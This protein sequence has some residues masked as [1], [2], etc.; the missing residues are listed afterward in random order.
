M[1]RIHLLFTIL[2]LLTASL[3]V[4]ACG[5]DDDENE[6][7]NENG[8]E[9][10]N[11]ETPAHPMTQA[12]QKEYLETVAKELMTLMPSTDFRDLADLG[13]Y[14]KDIYVEKYDWDDVGDWASDLFETARKSLGTTDKDESKSY[15]TYVYNNYRALLIASNYYAHF[16]A[17]NGRW[18]REKANDLQFSFTDKNG[19]PCVL[20]VET[21]GSTKDVCV[22]NYYDNSK[23]DYS[24]STYIKYYDRTKCIVR[25]PENIVVTLTQGG[26]QTMKTTVKINLKSLTGE[27]YDI[28]QNSLSVSTLVELNNG[29]RVNVSDI[30]Y[31]ANSKAA[32]QLSVSKNNQAL[33]SVSVASDV[34]GIPSCNVSAFSE[35]TFDFDNYDTESANAK[36][37]LVK[38]DVLGKVQLQ[39]VVADARKCYDYLESANDNK[40]KETDFKS[41]INQFNSLIDINLFYNN[42]SEKQA[43]VKMEAF[44]ESRWNGETRWDAEPVL[45][46]YDGTAYST[47]KAFFN[48]RDFK[49]VIDDFKN[50]SNRYANLIDQRIDW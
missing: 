10:V 36:G 38:I 48:D 18:I 12:E 35:K 21:S 34:S 5:D 43:S 22:L 9:I 15:R 26:R 42:K 49:A 2:A 17:N 44:S 1:K 7:K 3:V 30:T 11:P 46:F 13:M 45:Y 6:N 32:V 23:S 37:A 29:Y 39:G 33:V 27:E 24:G 50:L 41:Y 19:S 14:I 47:F 40:Y 31:Q 4:I 8:K 25:V 20:K 16:T 28:S